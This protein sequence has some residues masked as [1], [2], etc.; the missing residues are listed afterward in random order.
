VA[1]AGLLSLL[2]T[3]WAGPLVQINGSRFSGVNFASTDVAPLGYAAFAFALGVTVGLL[4]RRTIPAMAVTLGVFIVIQILMLGVIRPHLLPSTTTTIPLNQ[5]TM[6]QAHNISVRGS[7][8]GT[9]VYL[10][11][12]PAQT[13]T[14]VLSS[15]PVENSA[16]Q[17]IGMSTV[18]D[19]AR[20]AFGTG[21]G[22]LYD[23]LAADNL[24]ADITFQPADHYWP[25]QWYETGIFLALTALLSGFSFWWIRRRRD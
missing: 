9:A 7:T 24:H 14:W 21:S 17:P 12:L 16:D 25:L 15:S 23:C 4:L 2:I 3:W 5:T 20:V 13:G 1:F 22:H 10:G 19:C 18:T 8:S 6:S 11:D